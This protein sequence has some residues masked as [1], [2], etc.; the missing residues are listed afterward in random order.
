VNAF[1]ALRTRVADAERATKDAS[2]EQVAA[3][4]ADKAGLEAHVRAGGRAVDYPAAAPELAKAVEHARNEH[5]IMR[6]V[7]AEATLALGPALAG[8]AGA[9]AELA[10]A[11]IEHAAAAYRQAIDALEA[12]R[13]AYYAACHLGELWRRVTVRKTLTYVEGDVLHDARSRL[14]NGHIGSRFS[15]VDVNQA[16]FAGLRDDAAAHERLALAARW[17]AGDQLTQAERSSLGFGPVA[18]EEGRF[19][20]PRESRR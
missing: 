1:L 3:E 9:G 11:E 2:R 4:Q 19:D 18:G 10:A 17:E 13:R 5:Q 14:V 8:H 15:G 16:V 20:L 6:R 7:L 12:A